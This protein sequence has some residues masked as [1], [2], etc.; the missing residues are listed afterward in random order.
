MP[1]VADKVGSLANGQGVYRCR[2]CGETFS[3]PTTPI[4]CSWCRTNLV[5]V[6]DREVKNRGSIES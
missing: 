5:R 2:E 3:S 6:V 4:V 1:S